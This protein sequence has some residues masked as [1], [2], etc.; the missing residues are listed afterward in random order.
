MPLRTIGDAGH[1]T[2]ITALF[3]TAAERC[4]F[5]SGLQSGPRETWCVQL[6]HIALLM[7]D[8]QRVR[9]GAVNAAAFERACTAVVHLAVRAREGSA[10]P[11]CRHDENVARLTRQ[12]P[13]GV[14]Q[15]GMPFGHGADRRGGER[16]MREERHLQSGERQ[17]CVQS[18]GVALRIREAQPV[19]L[20]A[21]RAAVDLAGVRAVRSI[22]VGAREVDSGAVARRHR[23]LLVRA[24][25]V[26][27]L[28]GAAELAVIVLE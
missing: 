1:A 21:R 12:M 14:P 28:L 9:V 18:D 11:C 8:A 24:R 13:A 27:F 22:R 16:D 20:H 10:E 4:D 5:N 15:V 17:V 3:A 25:L 7:R 2:P 6:D 23:N 26:R 19:R